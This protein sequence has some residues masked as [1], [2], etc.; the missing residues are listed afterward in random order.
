MYHFYVSKHGCDDHSG[1]REA[2]FA[3][4]EKAVEAVRGVIAAGLDA[5][6][7]VTVTEG[8]YAIDGIVLD[9]RDSGTE[10]FPITY[11]AEGNVVLSGGVSLRAE[12]FTVLNEDEKARLHGAARDAVRKLDLKQYGL[13]RSD[14]GEISVIGT[15]STAKKYDDAVLSPLWCELF[16]DSERMRL[17]RYPNEGFLYTEEPV[18]QGDGLESSQG[19]RKTDAEWEAL[20]NPQGDVRRIDQDTA[21]RV[22]GWK[23]KEDIWVFGYPRYGWADESNLVEALDSDERTMATKYVSCYGIAPNAPYYFFNVLEELDAPGEWYLDREN[24]MIYVYPPKDPADCSI[25]LSISANPLWRGEGV[26]HVTLRGFLFEGTRGDAL[27]LTGNGNTV[28][29]CEI[30][31]VAGD[32]IHVTGSHCT[33]QNCHIHHLGKGGILVSGGDRSTLT[34]SENV[35]TNNHIHHYSEIFRTYCAAVKAIGVN[36]VVSH[37]C[38]HDSTHLAIGFHG[39][40]HVIEYNEISRVCRTSDDAGA[41]YSGRDYTNCGNIIRYNYFHDIVS[42]LDPQ[43]HGIFAVYCDDNNGKT[44]IYGNV[45]HRC[46]NAVL[47]HGGHEMTFCNNLIIDACDRS[48]CSIKWQHY[49]FWRSLIEGD[50]KHR[51]NGRWKAFNAVPWESDLW[52]K[53]FPHLCEY[54]TWDPETEQ[55][56]PHYCDI[57]GNLIV[58]HKQ[59]IVYFYNKE[60]FKNRVKNNL[61]IEDR[62]FVGIPEGDRLDLSHNRFAEII[63]NFQTIPLEKMGL[64]K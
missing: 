51:G 2:P 38:I 64:L 11:E 62:A 28:D 29:S 25:M 32:A 56:F 42:E 45:M 34:S 54:K 20:R 53:R 31:C 15:F 60:E 10:A 21:E 19:T 37:N 3:T 27:L 46:Q 48:L 22:R 14:W 24:G 33:V 50:E 55:R 26:N 49:V 44:D 6:V 23:S 5:P 4:L 18:R 43:T 35:I 58:N 40:D 17:A 12:D 7:T 57:S 41:V 9:A 63:P 52:R 30:R 8:E 36:C 16:V 1:T 47:F 59:F 13:M 61:E 39:N